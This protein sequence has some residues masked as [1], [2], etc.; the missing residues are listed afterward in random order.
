MN[1][2]GRT[3]RCPVTD[4]TLADVLIGAGIGGAATAGID[5]L[6]GQPVTWGGELKGAALGAAGGAAADMLGAGGA[7]AGAGGEGWGGATLASAE[8]GTSAAGLGTMT[9]GDIL[10]GTA[11]AAG[12]AAGALPEVTVSGLAAGGGGAA[13]AAGAGALAAGAGAAGTSADPNAP[14]PNQMKEI[15]VQ[16]SRLQDATAGTPLETSVAPALLAATNPQQYLARSKGTETAGVPAAET[17]GVDAGTF[18]PTGGF[19]PPDVAAGSPPLADY[20]PL[21]SSED[22]SFTDQ[23]W[24]TLK[25]PR[26]ALTAAG[27]GANLYGILARGQ[28]PGAAKTALGAAGPAVQRAESVIQTGGM[29]TPLW[30]TQKA[31]ID[32]QINQ[33]IAQAS[34]AIQQNAQASGMGGANSTAVQQQIASMTSQFETRRQAMYQQVLQNNVSNAVSELSGANQTLMSIAQLQ[35]QEN[36]YAQQLAGNIGKTTS[37][38]ATL[39]PTPSST[40]G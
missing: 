35:M 17:A 2:L 40:G 34:R 9:A 26:G 18:S 11:G 29:G 12:G 6:T 36:Q 14:D 15:Q 24:Q 39:W 13:G 5:A 37:A 23:L 38:L 28:L 22:P 3:Y 27:L 19:T 32:A 1:L 10:G 33:E 30:T 21:I 20:N 4:I 16:A 8:A 7:A 25:T 31:A